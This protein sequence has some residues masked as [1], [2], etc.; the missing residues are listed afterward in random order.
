MTGSGAVT[1][2]SRASPTND[3]VRA[4]VRRTEISSACMLSQAVKEQ[5]GAWCQL[6]TFVPS[7]SMMTGTNAVS[8]SPPRPAART[9]AVLSRRCQHHNKRNSGA[10]I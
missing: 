4:S 7:Y 8:R 9:S 3:H 1:A 10:S 5:N 2:A 6:C